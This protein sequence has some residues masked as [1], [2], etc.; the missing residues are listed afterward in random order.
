[1]TPSQSIAWAAWALAAALAAL[2]VVVAMAWQLR[3]AH[4]RLRRKRAILLSV[5]D[6]MEEGVVVTDGEGQIVMANRAA[7]RLGG[8]VR[9]QD[10]M[11]RWYLPSCH[12]WRDA[13]RPLS[14]REC[15]LGQAARGEACDG[16]ELLARGAP[17]VPDRWLNVRVRPLAT[18]SPG[19]L[20]GV[21]VFADVTARK[22]A[23]EE[24]RA[25]QQL[26]RETEF[27]REAAREEERKHIARELHDELGQHLSAL[28]ME[29]SLMRMRW[30]PMDAEIADKARAM[31]GSVDQ[32][33]RVVRNLVASLRPA[34]LDMGIGSALEWLVAE[35]AASGQVRCQL[36]LQ[37]ESVVLDANQTNLVFRLVQ[38]SL[39][40]VVRHARA[41]E[42]RV[43]LARHGEGYLL[44]VRDDG[45]GFDPTWRSP[46]SFGL[47]GM[48][49]RAEMLG[50]VLEIRS[51]PGE[52]TRIA[53]SFPAAHAAQP[54][55]A[56]SGWRAAGA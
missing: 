8:A 40:N 47:L 48:H 3:V 19:R 35:V 55:L 13:C 30:G 42:V 49:E 14:A 33:I 38:E 23:D 36:E 29:L 41:R 53:V 43:S 20:G 45:V 5:L 7:E 9:A 1:M 17:G 10:E 4:G 39:T 52:G 24:S 50:G 34:V 18:A 22:R 15:P 31:Q 54:A 37:E 6:S 32:V 2:A 44:M 25:L 16:A 12:F 28:R 21:V 11:D 46:T 27:R 26:R 56:P 51:S